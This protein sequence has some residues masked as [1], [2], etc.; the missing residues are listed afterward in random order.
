MGLL[1]IQVELQLV[2]SL[3]L[4]SPVVATSIGI[5]FSGETLSRLKA[6]ELPSSSRAWRRS[7]SHP[8]QERPDDSTGG[9]P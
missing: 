8:H 3:G 2:S 9:E 4:M 6:V 1:R 5:A 7:N